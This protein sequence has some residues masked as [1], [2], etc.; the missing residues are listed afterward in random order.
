V[1]NETA[2]TLTL[3]HG[4]HQLQL[5][6]TAQQQEKLLGYV[7]LL[8]KWNKAY[9]LTA[10]REPDEMLVKHILDSLTVVPF[11]DSVKAL[12]DIGAGAGLP[13]VVLAICFPNMQVY[14]LDSNIKKTRFMQQVV[15]E[16][17]LS[18]LQVVH[19]RA[20][21]SKLTQTFDVVI[22]RA[23]SSF[24]EFVELA[25]PRLTPH[26]KIYAMKG[27]YP[28]SELAEASLLC[29]INKVIP[30]TV[31]YLQ[32]DRHLIVASALLSNGKVK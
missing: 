28:E 16:L 18:N 25:L 2:L 31:P 1:P 5:D 15:Y 3:Q 32:E 20:D 27:R 11:C 22:S 9:N 12:L 8:H 6:L 4:L 19:A 23:F 14:G 7:S 26:G 29:D 21:T 24:S 30:L 17:T 10:V 13:S